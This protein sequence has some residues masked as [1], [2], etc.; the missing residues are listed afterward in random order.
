MP[1]ATMFCCHRVAVLC[2]SN[3]CTQHDVHGKEPLMEGWCVLCTSMCVCVKCSAMQP[4]NCAVNEIEQQTELCMAH[5]GKS[6]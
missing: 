6:F 3:V 1:V 2:M 4:P 5:Q